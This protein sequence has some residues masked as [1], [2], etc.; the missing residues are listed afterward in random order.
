MAGVG[1][2][3]QIHASH[4][5]ELAEET[6]SCELAALVDLDGDRARKVAA[7]LGCFAPI[8]ASLEKFFKADVA[9]ATVIV[10]PT[11]SHR[12]HAAAL[13]NAGQRV[14][15]TATSPP[16]SHRDIKAC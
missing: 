5:L 14:T 2:M 9:N 10:T 8:F 12:H 7:D 11:E 16:M 15:A 4:V 1:R 13:I 3:G 6:G